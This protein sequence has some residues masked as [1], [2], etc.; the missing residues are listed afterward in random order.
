M[1]MGQNKR[2]LDIQIAFLQVG[3]MKGGDWRDL[4]LAANAMMKR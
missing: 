4:F 3:H 1:Q 2:D